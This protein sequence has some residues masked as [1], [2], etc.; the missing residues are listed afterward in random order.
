V[1]VVELLE[2]YDVGEV[3]SNPFGVVD[4]HNCVSRASVEDQGNLLVVFDV[5]FWRCRLVIHLHVH[6]WTP[7]LVVVVGERF[8]VHELYNVLEQLERT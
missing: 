4:V 6:V 5:D 2:L 1:R 3:V 7:T 8:I